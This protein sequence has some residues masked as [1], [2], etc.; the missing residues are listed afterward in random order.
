MDIS[1]T[2]VKTVMALALLDP[3]ISMMLGGNTSSHGNVLRDV[4]AN[5]PNRKIAQ[6]NQKKALK[7]YRPAKVLVGM[8]SWYGGSF[9]GR[10]TRYGER[11]DRY[12]MTLA[13]RGLPYNTRVR[14]T[15]LRSGRS[16]EGR[17]NDYGPNGSHRRIVDLSEGLASAVG[18]KSQ[19]VGRVRIEV[20]K[21]R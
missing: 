21:R 17:V 14:I 1:T 9:H 11:F 5:R 4:D 15:N 13:S 6:A 12:G 10:R 2:V 16:A 18:L 7:G 3:S 8:A 20:L 19:G